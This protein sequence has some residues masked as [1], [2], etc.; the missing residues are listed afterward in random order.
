MATTRLLKYILPASCLWTSLRES[1]GFDYDQTLA[2]IKVLYPADEQNCMDDDSNL[3]AEAV[4]AEYPGYGWVQGC[5]GSTGSYDLV[6]FY[7]QGRHMNPPD[8]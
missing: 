5:Y 4:T 3:L 6:C 8:P 2:E 7:C 1:E